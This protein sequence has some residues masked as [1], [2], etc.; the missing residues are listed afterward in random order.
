[1]KFTRIALILLSVFYAGSASYADEI[2]KNSDQK[3]YIQPRQIHF[4]HDGFI[5]IES[6]SGMVGVTSIHQDAKGI[7]AVVA[8]KAPSETL[9]YCPENH[10]SP[11]GNGRCNKRGCPYAE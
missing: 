1:M 7:Y 6:P 10:Y 2:E 5:F 11:R 9:N 8:E 3:V 4:E